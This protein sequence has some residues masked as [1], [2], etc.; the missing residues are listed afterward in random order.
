MGDIRIHLVCTHCGAT[1][2]VPA[3]RID[4]EPVCGRCGKALD[5]ARPIELGDADF[6]AVI[7]ATKRP[8]LVDF[9]APWCGPCRMMAPA[10]EQAARQLGART[11]FVKV[12]SD[13]SPQLAGRYAVRSIPTLVR[14]ERG[15]EAARKSGA[16]PAGAI[17]ALAGG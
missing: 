8:V 2:R 14:I 9:W 7:G 3:A 1:N 17:V 15:R 6:D 12:N 4:D 11:L 5:Q 10:F 16:L 13:D